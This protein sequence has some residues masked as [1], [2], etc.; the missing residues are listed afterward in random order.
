MSD[1]FFW[2]FVVWLGLNAILGLIMWWIIWE[3][4]RTLP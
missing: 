3:T 1:F 2:A 4:K